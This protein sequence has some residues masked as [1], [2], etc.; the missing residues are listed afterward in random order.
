MLN[1]KKILTIASGS[2]ALMAI[3]GSVYAASSTD[4]TQPQA[5]TSTD[6]QVKGKHN[7]SN[8]ELLTLLGVDDATLKQDF[9][10]GQSLAD[11]AASKN[12]SEQQVI[13]LLVNQE[14]QRID[15]A[16]TSGKLTQDQ[17]DQKKSKLADE[18]KQRV[19][20]KGGFGGGRGRGHKDGGL[21]DVATVLGTTTTDLQTQLKAGQTIAQIA[22][23]QGIAESDLINQLLQ[24]DKDRLTKMVEQTWQQ[25]GDASTSATSDDAPTVQ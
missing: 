25:K 23:A 12:V 24:K 18:S 11:I 2:I 15:Q 13:D 4:T 20:N 16:V 1:K 3:T 8:Q 5:S 21:Q 19:E 10:S 22:Q 14:S 9:Q 7:H 6:N 17:A